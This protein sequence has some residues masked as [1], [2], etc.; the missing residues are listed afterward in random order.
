MK[1][2]EIESTIKEYKQNL[3]QVDSI[4]EIERQNTSLQ[5]LN[6]SKINDLVKL[7]KDLKAVFKEV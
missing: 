4:L 3:T 2:E 5:G 1:N 6:T 7:Q